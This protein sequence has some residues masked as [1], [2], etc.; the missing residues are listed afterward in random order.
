MAQSEAPRTLDPSSGTSALANLSYA[1]AVGILQQLSS[2]NPATKALYQHLADNFLSPNRNF[3][4]ELGENQRQYDLRFGEDQRQFNVN[5][6]DQQNLLN[7]LGLGSEGGGLLATLLGGDD[8]ASNDLLAQ[9]RAD[10]T[11]LVG[12]IQNYGQG[13]TNRINTQFQ[14]AEN[15]AL[16]NL[17]AR[18]LGASNLQTATRAGFAGEKNQAMLDLGDQLLG[19]RLDLEQG[20]LGNEYATQTGALDRD[21]QKKLQGISLI[22]SVAG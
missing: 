16:G 17:E 15:S 4:K 18:G 19:K 3:D 22:G 2:T 1:E 6:A 21:L 12:D 20:M 11:R 5:R 10:R 9:Q 14:S 13:Q 8:S 7:T